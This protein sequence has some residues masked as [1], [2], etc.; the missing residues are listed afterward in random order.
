MLSYGQI[1]IDT[2]NS[3][4]IEKNDKFEVTFQL[5]KDYQNKYSSDTIEVYAEFWN[6]STPII[7]VAGFYYEGYVRGDGTDPQYPIELSILNH[8]NIK[9][10]KVRFTP[11][12]AGNWNYKIVAKEHNSSNIWE[13]EIKSFFVENS[14]IPG[15]IHILQNDKYTAID[16]E[17]FYPVGV[18]LISP[19][20]LPNYWSGGLTYGINYYYYMIDKLV[21]NNMNFFRLWLDLNRGFSLIGH[22]Y[23]DNIDYGFS[24]YNQKDAWEIDSII[25]YA[26]Q[27]DVTI[28]LTLFDSHSWGN[29]KDTDSSWN[30]YSP[31]NILHGG[32]LVNGLGYTTDS[33]TIKKQKEYLRYVIARWGYA[34]NIHSWELWNEANEIL[35]TNTKL[36]IDS[37]NFINTIGVWHDTMALF[38]RKNDNSNHLIT[39][40]YSQYWPSYSNVFNS[41]DIVQSHFYKWL[42]IDKHPNKS[43]VEKYREVRADTLFEGKPYLS[44]EMGY[45]WKKDS[46][47]PTLYDPHGIQLH[48]YLSASLFM[49]DCGLPAFWHTIY[50]LWDN[51]LYFRYKGVGKF[52]KNI[53][54]TKNLESKHDSSANYNTYYLEDNTA[55]LVY[56]YMQ[57]TSMTFIN[58]KKTTNGASYVHTLNMANKPDVDTIN[59]TIDLEL[60]WTNKNVKVDWYSTYSGK[61]LMSEIY[62][63]DNNTLSITIPNTILR[64]TF[65]D[66][67]YVLNRDMGTDNYYNFS[68][69]VSLK[70]DWIIESG[71]T[72]E[73][74]DSTIINACQYKIIIRKGG[75]L[76]VDG[77]TI[78]SECGMWQGILV[79]GD[80]SATQT[81]ETN[82]GVL[83]VMNGATIKNAKNAIVVASFFDFLNPNNFPNFGGGIIKISNSSFVNNQKDIIMKPYFGNTSNNSVQKSYIKNCS[84]VNN[85]DMLTDDVMNKRKIGN[86][87]FEGINE[88]RITGNTFENLDNTLDTYNKGIG[89]SVNNSSVIIEAGCTPNIAPCDYTKPN[90]FINLYQG[91]RVI[92]GLSGSD[93]VKI[94]K[95]TFTNTYKAIFVSGTNGAEILENN[96][97]ASSQ[98]AVQSG[99]PDPGTPYG[100]YLN[101]GKG[102]K[103]E[104]NT[105]YRPASNGAATFNGARGIIVHNTGAEDNEI[106]K[107]TLNNLFLSEQSQGF[108][109]GKGTNAEKGLKFFCNKSH[110]DNGSFDVHVFGYPE[111]ELFSINW[112]GIATTQKQLIITSNG[113]SIDA[114]AGN[115][116]SNSHSSVN[117]PLDYDNG[118]GHEINYHWGN[119]NSYT[120]RFDPTKKDNI[121]TYF[122]PGIFD[123]C[124]TKI[125]IDDNGN[126]NQTELYTRLNT[127]QIVYNSD[128]VLLNIWKDGGNAN[129]KEEV[130]TTQPWDVYV[131]FN[132]LISKSPYLS[133]DVMIET[134]YNE[135]FTNLM[136]KL[137][138]IANP[139][140]RKNIEIMDAIY[141]RIPAM[142]VNYIED[143]N[144]SPEVSS[145]LKLLEANVNADNHLIN[146]I[147]ESIKRM[148]K[149]DKEHVWAKDSLIEFMSRKVD[150]YDKYELANLYLTYNKFDDYENIMSNIENTFEMNDDMINEYENFSNVFSI[151]KTLKEQNLYEKSLSDNQRDMLFAIIEDDKPI[152]LPYALAV[153]KRDNPNFEYLEQVYDVERNS[154]RM[155]NDNLTKQSISNSNNDFKVYPN[156]TKDYITLSYNCKFENITYLIIN[157]QGKVLISKKLATIVDFEH[158]EVLLNLVNISTGSYQLIVKS[159]E[160]Q[161]W[162]EVIMINK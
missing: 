133:D 68:G 120:G 127:A 125:V 23:Q 49:G 21:E 124:P 145:Q 61:I 58:V 14:D 2:V 16:N 143:I 40:S 19:K 119:I 102:F 50:Y 81:S 80:I 83:E 73:L 45:W 101:G 6:N 109:S 117:Q 82:Q 155:T 95:N 70:D 103:V 29:T 151:T 42:Y 79:Q 142:P 63:S 18:N 137:L 156:P 139:H 13:S 96:I 48:N 99:K 128:K 9:K 132:N 28:M 8:N 93:I 115:I 69:N 55:G 86:I 105:I 134:I 136:I 1:T 10:W 158:N 121:K 91:I 62:K 160:T 11:K 116:F 146:I 89:I 35:K 33:Y 72:I 26:R 74:N 41:M 161:L 43:Y 30:N 138:M 118:M 150:L 97:K 154:S 84:F 15:N 59:T 71:Q 17:P 94:S 76:I 67:F 3:L 25:E 39:T 104:E 66:A 152:I 7:Q 31:Y 114:P 157:M 78:T 56:G 60:N 53:D 126:G 20:P 129:L 92:N 47:P 24:N 148:Y 108:N 46:L 4:I 51:D 57:D 38:I 12:I 87:Y 34:N 54:F 98:V 22:D 85:T 52:V 36:D 110:T 37:I 112:P 27:K 141:K 111:I 107:N 159:N 113:I 90:K 147:G 162:Q 123:A 131:E 32:N 149:A 122:M 144:N 65:S 153:L 64:D 75:K 130:K 106:Y 140:A 77:A 88:I 135:G 5:Q 44:G 100:I